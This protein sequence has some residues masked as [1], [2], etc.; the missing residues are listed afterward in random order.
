MIQARLPADW[1]GHESVLRPASPPAHAVNGLW[2]F[3]IATS[4]VVYVL[5]IAATVYAMYRA[6]GRRRAA[7]QI[8]NRKVT[9][10]NVGSSAPNGHER[11]LLPGEAET[12]RTMHR[13]V[14]LS[15][16]ATV[17]ILFAFLLYDFGV[18]RAVEAPLHAPGTLHV[19]LVGH[20]WWWE[21]QYQDTATQRRVT[22]ANEIHVPVKRPIIFTLTSQDVIHSF[23][24]PNLNGKKDLVPGHANDAWFQAD[25]PG[26]YRG[27][28]AEFCGLEHAKMALVIIA[29]P[30][31]EFDRW[32]EEQLQSAADPSD[33]LR[34]AGKRV[35]LAG[36]CS[37]CH[38]IA[39]T[40]A[41]AN[42]GPDLTHFGSRTMLAA[43][44]LPN[45]VGNLGGWIMDPQSIKPG[46][47]MPANGLEPRDLRA[48]IAYLE[49]LR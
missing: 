25:T 47:K 28:C 42:Y 20:Q 22:T 4:T 36:S 34:A 37:M 16:A 31:G 11:E 9:A 46:A 24:I 27:Q 41:G 14:L 3:M 43:G 30:K 35:F 8:A 40:S 21:V 44:T 17:L 18:G 38:S 19:N 39:G 45:T 29:E 32:Y 23:W 2:H 10:P 5:V 1:S 48:V 15:T 49:G 33:S 12:H 6:A 26:V 13:A 7:D